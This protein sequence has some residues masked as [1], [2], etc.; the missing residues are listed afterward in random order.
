MASPDHFLKYQDRMVFVKSNAV[1]CI[2][3][4]YEFVLI[5]VS[6][7]IIGGSE[8]GVRLTF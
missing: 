7:V 1:F 8:I 5:F 4:S 2:T 6:W 3:L